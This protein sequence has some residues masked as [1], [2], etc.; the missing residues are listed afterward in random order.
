[1]TALDKGK[2]VS[3]DQFE[4]EQDPSPKTKETI[5][6]ITAGVR[7]ARN[8]K[9]VKIINRAGDEVVFDTMTDVSTYLKVSLQTVWNCLNGR[10][11]QT[12]GWEIRFC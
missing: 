5:Q 9:P 8:S 7:K 12:K 10:Q 2:L 11:Q 3:R 4:E 1:M 6:K